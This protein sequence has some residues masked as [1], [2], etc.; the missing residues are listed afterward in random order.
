M[1]EAKRVASGTYG[2]LWWNGDPVAE[3]YKFESKYSKNKEDVAL[4][5]NFV[6]DSKTTSVKGTGSIGIYRVFNR[7]K[8]YADAIVQGKD[9][10]ATFIGKL[11]DPDCTDGAARVAF[12]GVS[13]DDVPLL[14]FEAGQIIKTEVPFT[15]TG[16]KYLE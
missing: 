6:V 3:A 5:G 7:W 2:T 4:C 11:A 14:N 10:R 13:F 9:E 12:Y 1:L 16:H 8:E 15:F